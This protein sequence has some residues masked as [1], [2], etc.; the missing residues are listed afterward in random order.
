[1]MVILVSLRRLAWGYAVKLGRI[2]ICETKG[3]AVELWTLMES[4]FSTMLRL[5]M[6]P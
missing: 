6:H 5:M 3:V 2:V 1:M 4:M